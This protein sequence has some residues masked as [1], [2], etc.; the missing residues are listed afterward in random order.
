[1]GQLDQGMTRTQVVA[2]IEQSM[3]F[4]T[5]VVQKGY[6]QFLH[7][8]ADQAGLNFWVNFLQ[9]GHTVEQMEAGLAGSPEYFQNRGGGTNAGFLAALYQDALG[10]TIDAGGQA[11]FTQAL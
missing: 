11:A 9:Q 7:R 4:Q 1:M 10:R 2:A 3:E 6:Q 5:N 8:A